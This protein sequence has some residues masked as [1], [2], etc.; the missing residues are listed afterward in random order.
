MIFG[1]FGSSPRVWGIPK[2]YVDKQ[3][4]ER[5]I[6]T[7]VGNTMCAQCGTGA[8]TV[9][10]HA[11]GE[12]AT[13]KRRKAW[14]RGSSPRVWGILDDD[15]KAFGIERFI[16]TRVG[17]TVSRRMH[18][19]RRSVHPHACGEYFAQRPSLLP[20][21]GSS[22]R[23]WGIRCPPL[24][25]LYSTRFIPTRVGNT[26]GRGNGLR[27]R[28]VHP[29]AC[30]EYREWAI[31]H[32]KSAGSSPRVWGILSSQSSTARQKRFI[33][34]RVGNTCT[35]SPAWARRPV[36]PHACGE[37]VVGSDDPFCFDGSSPRVWGIPKPPAP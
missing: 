2:Q 29:H 19:Q 12:Y 3:A 36:H 7:R 22:P 10:P 16:P 20:K 4:V 13:G 18:R 35:V 37:Y 6:P 32:Q 26:R 21:T 27:W 1:G 11:C 28:T 15:V 33:P 17:N 24:P 30:G 31:C 8:A 34:T 9:H 5:F 23:V 14:N 25:L